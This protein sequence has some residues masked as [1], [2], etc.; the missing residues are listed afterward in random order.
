MKIVTLIG[1]WFFFNRLPWERLGLTMESFLL[2]TTL[3]SNLS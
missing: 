2:E 1:I 3:S